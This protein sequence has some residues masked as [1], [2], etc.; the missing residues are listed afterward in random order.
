MEN[1]E[2]H[3]SNEKELHYKV[4]DFIKRFK[5]DI[6]LIPGLGENQKT[7][8]VRS[9]SFFKAYES[10]QVDILILNPHRYYQGLAIELKTPNGK[11]NTSNKQKEYLNKLENLNFKV[12]VSN[13]YDAI[14]VELLN[15]FRHVLFPCKYCQGRKYNSREKLERH[16]RYFHKIN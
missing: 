6:M 10:G 16:D 1:H 9:D 13:D 12:L 11:N 4:V 2:F 14:V 8:Q 3:L 7:T 15:Y 5:P